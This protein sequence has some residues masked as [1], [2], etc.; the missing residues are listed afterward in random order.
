MELQQKEDKLSLKNKGIDVIQEH[1][2]VVD[3]AEQERRGRVEA[4]SHVKELRD[5]RSLWMFSFSFS[6]LSFLRFILPC[7]R[8]SR[9]PLSAKH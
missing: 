4:R 5:A 1:D 7:C 8:S 2:R 6:F 9:R 3:V